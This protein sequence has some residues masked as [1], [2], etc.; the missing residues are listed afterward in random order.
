MTL[1]SDIITDAYRRSNLIAVGQTPST[2]Q[3][4]EALRYLN[5]IVKSVFGNE[6]GEKLEAFPIGRHNIKRPAGYPWWNN[7]P[8]NNFYLP[9]NVRVMMNI[10]DNT[11]IDLYLHPDPPFGCRFAYNFMDPGRGQSATI[12]GNGRYLDGSD[13]INLDGTTTEAE[14]LYRDDLA[15]W[16]KYAPI[17]ITD[18]F[19]FPIEFDDFFITGLAMVINPSY[20]QT[21]DPQS[22]AVFK[23]AAQQLRSRYHQTINTR[24]ELGLIRFT[25]T[26]ADRDLWGNI[27]WLYNPSDMFAKG[28]PW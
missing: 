3:Q 11:H 23:R 14:Y 25:R 1:V 13:S 15:S 24:S 10:D 19:P 22:Q 6:V 5:R 18:T 16:V 2:A 7:V 17:L 4:T 12:Y 8:D 27:Y 9:P 26:A 28:W 21:L 20:G